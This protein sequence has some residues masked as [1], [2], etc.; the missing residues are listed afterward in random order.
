MGLQ[1]ALGSRAVSDVILNE[2]KKWRADLVVMG[3]HGRRGVN[4]ILLGSDV[5]RIV[6]EEPVP[7]LLVRGDPPT[8]RAAKKPVA[9]KR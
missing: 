1:E 3:T 7:V 5:E 2:A 6:R 8:R 4:R 9:P